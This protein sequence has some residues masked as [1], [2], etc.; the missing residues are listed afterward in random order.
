MMAGLQ[1]RGDTYRGNFRYEGRLHFLSL[2]QVSKQEADT[3]VAQ[4]EYLLMRLK[5]RVAVA[6]A[7]QD[8]TTSSTR[9]DDNFSEQAVSDTREIS[10]DAS[11]SSPQTSL[12]P[13]KNSM[14]FPVASLDIQSEA[15][16]NGVGW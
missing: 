11:C 15:L 10:T 16:P 5:L 13:Q 14:D 7:L 8:M 9:R 3:K 6:S 12:D 1:L 2:G 4:V